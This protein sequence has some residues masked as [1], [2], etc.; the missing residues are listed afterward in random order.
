MVRKLMK[1]SFLQSERKL[2][3]K[4]WRIFPNSGSNS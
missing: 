4:Q 2:Y 3:G 1:R